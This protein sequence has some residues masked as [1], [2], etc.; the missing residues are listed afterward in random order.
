MVKT[1]SGTPRPRTRAERKEVVHGVSVHPTTVLQDGEQNKKRFSEII[2]TKKMI[3][4]SRSRAI[5][6]IVVQRNTLGNTFDT[7]SCLIH[8]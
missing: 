6:E 8:T 2:L 1:R 5:V 7:P 3:N 4:I